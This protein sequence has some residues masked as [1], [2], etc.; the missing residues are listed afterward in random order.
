[1][2]ELKYVE[3]LSNIYDGVLLRKYTA[4]KTA[5]T[6]R[7]WSHLL[8]KSV[9]VNFIFLCNAFGWIGWILIG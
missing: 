4:Q 1:M 9:M 3:D 5:G 7:I 2:K 8:K 6:L